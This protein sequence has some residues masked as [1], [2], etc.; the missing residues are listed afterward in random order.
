LK[1]ATDI[2]ITQKVAQFM[3][4]IMERLSAEI[5]VMKYRLIIKIAAQTDTTSEKMDSKQEQM[6]SNT[7]E[8]FVK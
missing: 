8:I 7:E 5:T 6:A 1:N 2:I 3:E 4:K